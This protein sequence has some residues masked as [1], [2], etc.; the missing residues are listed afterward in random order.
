MLD[1]TCVEN[2]P[3]ELCFPH[4]ITLDI[5]REDKIH[6]F[7]SGNKYRKLKY[8]LL[9]AQRQNKKT[10][11][12]FGGAFSNHISTTA[13]AGQISGYKTIGIIRGDELKDKIQENPTLSF[14]QKCG[15]Q[16][17]FISRAEY[18]LK[19]TSSFIKQIYNQ[20]GEDIYLVPEGGTNAWAVKGC[21]EIITLEDA[22]YDVIACAVGTGGTL[23]GIINAS[24]PHQN[25][26]GFP[27][28]QGDFLYN[29]IRKYVSKTNW[30][31]I[32]DYNFGGYAKVSDE[33]VH[34]LNDFYLK[35]KIPLDPIYTGKMIF[36]IFALINKGFFKA[37]SKI[38]AIHTGGLQGIAGLNQKREKQHRKTLIYD[39]EI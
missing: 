1:I 12:T 7:I 37:N 30:K 16:L 9:E 13:Y 11:L 23:A 39:E 19:N 5:K 26:I 6:R 2:Q 21:Q 35:T 29:E 32:Y 38:L 14:A 24:F 18:R 31:L 20:F 15:M 8:N 36:A 17:H 25:V 4:G 34:F 22:K 3:I 33:L 28:L 27:A 10:L